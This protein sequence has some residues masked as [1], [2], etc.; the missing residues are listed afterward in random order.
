MR[1]GVLAVLL[2][3]C[4]ADATDVTI[5]LT[6]DD[7][8]CDAVFPDV[9]A[10]SIEVILNTK[11]C[12]LAHECATRSVPPKSLAAAIEALKET[13]DVLVELDAEESQTL[14]INGR[15]HN[16][17]FPSETDPNKPILCGYASLKSAQDGQLKVE[18]GPDQPR[19]D[20]PESM[21]LCP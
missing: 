19:G 16:S 13:A 14:V 3:A 17:C 15:P 2:A 18:L 10:I 12:R 1:I 21:M 4:G 7:H 11:G 9:E 20:C 6:D 8:D 5:V